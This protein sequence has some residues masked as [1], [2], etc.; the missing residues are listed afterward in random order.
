MNLIIRG[1]VRSSF[2][3]GRLRDLVGRMCESVG[4]KIFIH[5]WNIR[6]SSTSW[7]GLREDRKPIDEAIVRGYFGDLCSSIKSVTVEDDKD[8][9]VFGS[10]EG[11]VASTGCPVLGYKFML[12]GM[13]K[14]AEEVVRVAGRNELVSQMR[15]DVFS[16]WAASRAESVLG[17]MRMEPSS[18]ERIRFMVRPAESE[19]ELSMRLGRWRKWGAEYEPHWTV[20]IDNVYMARA[21]DML[22]F[23]SHMYRDFDEL[24]DKYKAINHQEWIAMFE[25]FERGWVRG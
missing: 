6:Q 9:E 16:N 3:D 20:G 18:W 19:R 17:F 8:V 25:A 5:T 11:R 10:R 2:E 14:A 21:G 12:Y 7:R 13:A 24:N 15:F 22:D 1:H 23:Q 4:V